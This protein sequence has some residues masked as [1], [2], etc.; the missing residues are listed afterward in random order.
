METAF[1]AR[2]RATEVEDNVPRRR[3]PKIFSAEVPRSPSSDRA[4]QQLGWARDCFS[5]ADLGD[6]GRGRRPSAAAQA[7]VVIPRGVRRPMTP[8]ATVGQNPFS[9]ISR[10]ACVTP[11]RWSQDLLLRRRVQEGGG[12]GDRRRE[13][14][15]FFLINFFKYFVN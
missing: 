13:H 6:R 15:F 9:G 1:T 14:E 5:V 2:I 3:D 7:P 11:R 12:R 4:S 10:W 8:T